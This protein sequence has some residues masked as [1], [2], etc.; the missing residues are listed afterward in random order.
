MRTG[1]PGKLPPPVPGYIDSLPMQ[2]RVMLEHI[3][4]ASATGTPAQV[5]QAITAFLDRTGADELIVSGP[6]FDPAARIRSLELTADVL[7]A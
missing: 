4:Q 1:N 2:G 3:G 5:K 7:S 6:T